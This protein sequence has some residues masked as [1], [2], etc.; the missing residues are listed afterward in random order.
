[1]ETGKTGKYFK[2]AI[3]EIILVMIGILLA[4]QVNNWNENKQAQVRVNSRLINLTQ[5]IESDIVEMNEILQV[6]KDRIIIIKSILEGSNRLGSFGITESSN[7]LNSFRVFEEPTFEPT[8]NNYENPNSILSRLR[9]LD[10]N[11]PTY[12][13]L[14]NSGEFHLIKNQKLAKKI[15]AYY[16]NVDETKDR[17]NTNNKPSNV[18]IYK[19]K[20]RLGLGTHSKDGTMEKLIELAKKD[21]QF[22]AELEHRYTMDLAQYNNTSQLKLKAQDLI[23]AIESRKIN[24]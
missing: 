13:E 12:S 15:Q 2:Y 14:I 22:G 11:G 7:G 18:A 24:N 9:T 19:S 6:A 21:Q 3:G 10:G 23:E 1:M 20:N 16:F 8:T 4:L 17:E 5:D